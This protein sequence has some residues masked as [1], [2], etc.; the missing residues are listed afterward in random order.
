MRRHGRSERL[1]PGRADFIERSAEAD[2]VDVR[3]GGK[4]GDQHGNVVVRTLAVG[5]FGEQERLALAFG[6][7]AAILPAHQRVHLGVFVDRLVDHD[8]TAGAI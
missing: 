8:E 6:D 4:P 5:G 1:H 2:P 3:I 7:A